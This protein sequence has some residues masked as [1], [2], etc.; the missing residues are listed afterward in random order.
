[1]MIE[2][3]ESRRLM[4]VSIGTVETTITSDSPPLI[5]AGVIR[6]IADQVVKAINDAA[7]QA[8]RRQ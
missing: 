7:A 6:V 8:A 5:D 2:N 1:M 4:S 3:L